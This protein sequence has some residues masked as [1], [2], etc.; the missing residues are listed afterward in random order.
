MWWQG[1]GTH[2]HQKFDILPSTQLLARAQVS[3][4]CD[5]TRWHWITADAQ[6]QG[7]GQRGRVWQSPLGGLYTTVTLLW[8]DP[9]LL[10]LIPLL[11]GLSICRVLEAYSIRPAIKWIND[12]FVSGKKIAGILTE[13]HGETDSGHRVL[14]GIGININAVGNM[15]I[16][17]KECLG[18]RVDLGDIMV[19]LC[20]Q[21]LF[22]FKECLGGKPVHQDIE[23]RLL[24]RHE[25]VYLFQEHAVFHGIFEG[26]TPEGFLKMDAGR[27]F[28]TGRLRNI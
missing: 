23:A 25:N 15:G 22:H 11:T 9:A 4:F 18:H 27:I 28:H 24:Y 19:A 5:P 20:G 2:T 3:D 1:N 21:L 26:I 17:L 12:V 13:C 16:S 6:Q 14:L 10:T 8:P 7:Q